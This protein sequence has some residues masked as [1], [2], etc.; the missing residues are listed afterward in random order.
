MPPVPRDHAKR[1]RAAVPRL[2]VMLKSDDE[3]V[4]DGAIGALVALREPL[5]VKTLTELAEFRNLDM[6]RRIIDAIG[7][8]GGDDARAYLELVATG[9]EVP[10]V[11][12]LAAGALSRL[13]RRTVDARSH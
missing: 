13:N 11:R 8:I 10:A 4:R 6:M 7:G 12:D 3:L 9:H 1:L 2:L 5:A